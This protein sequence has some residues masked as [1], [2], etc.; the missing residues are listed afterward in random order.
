MNFPAEKEYTTP[1]RVFAVGPTKLAA[2]VA[3]ATTRTPAIN[4]AFVQ[5]GKFFTSVLQDMDRLGLFG[6]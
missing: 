3:I 2:V 4:A 5:V 6:P 1:F